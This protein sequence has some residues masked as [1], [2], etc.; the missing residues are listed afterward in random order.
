ME[1]S[2]TPNFKSGPKGAN[3]KGNQKSE[4][5]GELRKHWALKVSVGVV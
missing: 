3:E 4:I 2:E 1:N 5:D